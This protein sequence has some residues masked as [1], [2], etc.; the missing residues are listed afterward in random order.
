MEISQ[1]QK[2]INT[3]I[4]TNHDQCIFQSLTS[5]G[6]AH[7]VTLSIE[8]TTSKPVTHRPYRCPEK[9]KAEFRRIIEDLLDAKIIQES[10]SPYSSPALLVNKKDG[11]K[12][13]VIDYRAL[14]RIT[15]KNKF[16]MPIIEEIMNSLHG[17]RIFTSLDLASDY[18]QIPMEQNSIPY[19]AFSTPERHY[20]F[21]RVP[22]GL[23]NAPAVFQQFMNEALQQF[24][25]FNIVPYLDDTLTPFQKPL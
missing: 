17:Y 12:R 6:K 5:L 24:R 22:F 11:S 23:C 14:N 1:K 2:K 19:T 18:H 7:W 3:P 13:L 20:K 10:K 21:L 9:D 4:L 16:S 15:V 8:L 25:T